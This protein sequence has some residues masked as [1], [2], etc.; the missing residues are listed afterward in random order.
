MPNAWISEVSQNSGGAL[1]GVSVCEEHGTRQETF[2]ATSFEATVV[3]RVPWNYRF[4]VMWDIYQNN[5]PYPDAVGTGSSDKPS[6][7]I[8]TFG[9]VPFPSKQVAAPDEVIEYEDALITCKYSTDEADSQQLY[10]QTLEPLIENQVLDKTLF[11][12]GTAGGS[13]FK[14]ELF[15]KE[16]P[17]KLHCMWTYTVRWIQQKQIPIEYAKLAGRVNDAAYTIRGVFPDGSD[18]V[19][20]IEGMLY[21]P[22]A[23]QK[24]VYLKLAGGGAGTPIGEKIPYP[25]WDYTLRFHINT[26]DDASG[27]PVGVWNRPFQGDADSPTNEIDYYT[28]IWRKKDPGP[29]EKFLTYT[30]KTFPVDDGTANGVHFLPKSTAPAP[31]IA[32]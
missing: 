4:A 14:R 22:G 31:R 23:M 30:S 27:A 1:E 18:F 28:P 32:K 21:Q 3:L 24:S 12:R 17:A 20:P 19:V 6:A 9:V 2:G 25:G 8:S 15:D 26:I 5:V 29:N 10:V 16:A 11:C 13:S 7:F